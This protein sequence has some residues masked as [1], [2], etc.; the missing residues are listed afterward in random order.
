VEGIG[1]A[2]LSALLTGDGAALAPTLTPL[3]K[4]FGHVDV[5]RS[6]EPSQ[7]TL[8]AGSEALAFTASL[9]G[10]KDYR[11]SGTC[12]GRLEP[13]R[14]CTLD[15][16]FA[17]TTGGPLSAVL[18]VTP[19]GGLPALTSELAGT[20]DVVPTRLAPDTT[21]FD[22][23][24]AGRRSAAATFTVTV[25]SAPLGPLTPSA[26]SNDFTV[27]RNGCD[28]RL[29]AFSTCSFDVVFSPTADGDHRA[30]IDVRG[31]S[32]IS[33]TVTGVSPRAAWSTEPE[34]LYLWLAYY[35]TTASG[36]VTV[37]VS[38]TSDAPV[39]DPRVDVTGSSN[40]RATGCETTVA[41]GASCDIEVVFEAPGPTVDTTERATLVISS[42]NGGTK[43][44]PL[45]AGAGAS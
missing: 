25:G 45:T 22:K 42:A 32:G 14:S 5:G 30:R 37:E 1:G 6:D 16:A 4:D 26:T 23:T 28:E 35:E 36:T 29:A 41:V 3:S 34:Q 44:V 19:K 33:A 38:G 40:F 15:V 11:L 7:F 20:G 12:T 2:P 39:V 27:V 31:A 10:T 43:E 8:V 24:V 9:G 13:H 21:H 18:T 17:P